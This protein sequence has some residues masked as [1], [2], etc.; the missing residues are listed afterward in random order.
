MRTP[1]R[2]H[3]QQREHEKR[4]AEHRDR[5]VREGDHPYHDTLEEKHDHD[6]PQRFR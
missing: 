6:L 1:H 4:E 5:A 3:A 2:T